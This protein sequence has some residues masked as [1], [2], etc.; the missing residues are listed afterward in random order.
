MPLVVPVTTVQDTQ[1]GPNDP[2]GQVL[3]GSAS[4]P[5]AFFGGTPIPQILQGTLAGR[6]GI[7]KIYTTSQSPSAVTANTTAEFSMTVTGVAA[8]DMVVAVNKPTTQ[9]GLAVGTARVSATNTV[10]VEFGNLTGSTI[11]PTTTESYVV[12]TA[13]S[14]LQFPA[15][16]LT[17]AAVV[18]NTTV[19]QSFTVAGVQTGMWVAVTK[20]TTQAGLLV[21][22]AR[23]LAPDTVGVTFMN[24]T[25]ST[26]TPTAGESYLFFGCQG[27]RLQPVSQTITVSLTP[28]AVAANTTAEQTFTVA[29]LPST[30]SVGVSE[31]PTAMAGMAIVGVRVSAANTLAINFANATAASM[32]PPAGTY[33]FE[34]FPAPIAAAGSSITFN[35]AMGMEAPQVL[36]NHGLTGVGT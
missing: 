36:A 14:A 19:E 31:L 28:T 22:G 4:T 2:A 13:S 5:L 23:V 30:A 3:P 29:N 18:A 32:T 6:N 26:I 34:V 24:V 25:A 10:L 35:A 12:V 21:C 15:V 11:T 17:P 9:A 20:P 1:I 33:T 7:L 8:T 27:L 16:T